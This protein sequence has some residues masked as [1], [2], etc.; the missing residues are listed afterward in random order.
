MSAVKSVTNWWCSV[1]GWRF[2]VRPDKMHISAF[3]RCPA[4][5]SQETEREDECP[6]HGKH[7][8]TKQ[9]RNTIYGHREFVMCTWCGQEP[10]A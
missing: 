6:A 1:C 4:C 3:T 8:F 10:K 7:N 5:G 9:V 2:Y